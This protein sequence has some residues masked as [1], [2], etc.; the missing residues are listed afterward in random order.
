M[1]LTAGLFNSGISKGGLFNGG[2][3]ESNGDALASLITSLFSSGEQGGLWLPGLDTCYTDNGTTLCTAPG[4]LVYR[5][6]DL[7]GNGNHATNSTTASMP[8]LRQTAGGLWY[9][10]F[11]GVDDYLFLPNI[12]F[13][14]DTGF[15]VYA[16]VDTTLLGD[17]YRILIYTQSSLRDN[18]P[19]ICLGT[20]DFSPAIYDVSDP[21]AINTATKDLY[22][23]CWRTKLLSGSTRK[24]TTR[25]NR[26][27]VNQSYTRILESGEVA[28]LIN[29]PGSQAS[30]INLFG[31][32]IRCAPL[33]SDTLRDQTELFI[34]DR[35][36]VTLP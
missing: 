23:G 13:V 33:L 19:N 36:G 1:S 24:S 14:A 18:T 16:G 5:I 30:K 22:V 17:L 34:A 2:I 21:R 25:V 3:F 10:E 27:E 20:T 26:N 7:S 31:L 28:S 32:A 11:D 29:L 8:V 6:D 35:T 9:L 4:D 12:P 15:D